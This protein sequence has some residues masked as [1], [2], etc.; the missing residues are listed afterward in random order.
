MT[1]VILLIRILSSIMFVNAALEQN[2]EVLGA[3][4]IYF[5]YNIT[6]EKI[7]T[8]KVLKGNSLNCLEENLEIMF[9]YGAEDVKAFIQ[10]EKID[11]TLHDRQ[12]KGDICKVYRKYFINDEKVLVSIGYKVTLVE[13]ENLNSFINWGLIKNFYLWQWVAYNL[14]C[15]D[16]VK[17]VPIYFTGLKAI[18]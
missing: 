16:S 14:D 11:N 9:K 2:L 1:R 18:F 17:D 4:D 12:I 13:I 6:C 15:Y 7:I 3:S 10:P 5:C 8:F